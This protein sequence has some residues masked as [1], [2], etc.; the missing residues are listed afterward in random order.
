MTFADDFG[1]CVVQMDKMVEA[2]LPQDLDSME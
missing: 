2:A 1:D